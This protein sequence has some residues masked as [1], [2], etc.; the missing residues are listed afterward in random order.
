[1]FKYLS[2][3]KRWKNYILEKALATEGFNDCFVNLEKKLNN[4]IRM[5]SLNTNK[6]ISEGVDK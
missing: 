3:F 2:V 5:I 4:E 1:M 6:C